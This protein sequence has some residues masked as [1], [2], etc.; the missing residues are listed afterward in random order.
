MELTKQNQ[1]S[2]L[3]VGEMAVSLYAVDKGY[4]D[5]VEVNKVVAFEAALHDYLRSSE[6][7]LMDEINSTGAYNDDIEAGI[8]KAI[9]TFKANNVW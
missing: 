3:S 9:E 1:Y 8:K 4:V 7:E 2:P 5:D 6:K